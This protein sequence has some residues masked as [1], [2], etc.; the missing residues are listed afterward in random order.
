MEQ[1]C[2]QAQKSSSVSTFTLEIHTYV[3]VTIYI[4]M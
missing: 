1:S 4:N 2:A 3:S